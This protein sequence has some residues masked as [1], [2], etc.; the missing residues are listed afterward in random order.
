MKVETFEDLGPCRPP[1]WTGIALR[2]AV[3]CCSSSR[4]PWSLTSRCK[5]SSSDVCFYYFVSLGFLLSIRHIAD[6]K[7]ENILKKI[8][9]FPWKYLKHKSSYSILT[10]GQKGKGKVV[11]TAANIAHPSLSETKCC[12]TWRQLWLCWWLLSLYLLAKVRLP[13]LCHQ[14]VTETKVPQ[15]VVSHCLAS[16]DEFLPWYCYFLLDESVAKFVYYLS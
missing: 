10:C 3:F 13:R 4:F 1:N 12:V 7:Y 6:L 2:F 9:F 5:T 11:S 16:A 8:V 15:T 14:G